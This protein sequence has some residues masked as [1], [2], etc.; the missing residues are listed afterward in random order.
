MLANIPAE[1][2]SSVSIIHGPKMSIAT[3]TPMSFGTNVS[4][5]SFTW[6]TAWM[7]L[8]TMPTTRLTPRIGRANFER[9]EQRLASK[10]E[11]DRF[12]HAGV[13]FS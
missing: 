6:V 4:V 12:V 11:D 5:I 13:P 2:P 1:K 7:R 3:K 10:A 8:T 9:D